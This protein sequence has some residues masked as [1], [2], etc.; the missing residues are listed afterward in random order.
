MYNI[1]FDNSTHNSGLCDREIETLM[2]ISKASF[3]VNTLVVV[4][5]VVVVH[6]FTV[7]LMSQEGKH[8]TYGRFRTLQQIR[9]PFP[10]AT[11][12]C[13]L[14][15]FDRD[16]QFSFLAAFRRNR[17]QSCLCLFAL[18]FWMSSAV[19]FWRFFP[20]ATLTQ[21]RACDRF[22]HS[23]LCFL[24]KETWPAAAVACMYILW[25]FFF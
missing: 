11:R 10:G 4:V 3:N 12:K 2:L 18:F 25:L 5:V 24:L 7:T 23:R 6:F 1:Y 16:L 20:L 19:A 9:R 13:L 22:F 21:A 14:Q 8:W 15:I 17:K